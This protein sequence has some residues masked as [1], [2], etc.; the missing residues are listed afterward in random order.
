M[1]FQQNPSGFFWFCA[2]E[3]CQ[4]K[5]LYKF[6]REPCPCKL[7]QLTVDTIGLQIRLE[8]IASDL[9]MKHSKVK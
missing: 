4:V 3:I 2:R 8:K 1:D 5:R 9:G 6:H 7:L